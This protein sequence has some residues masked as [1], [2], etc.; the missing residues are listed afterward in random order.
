MIG[1]TVSH[2]KILEYLGEGGMGVVYKAEDIILNRSVT[3][4]FLPHE[5]TR[6]EEAKKRFILEA[7]AASSLDHANICVVHEIDH[8]NDGQ[9]FICMNYYEGETL[10][11]KIEKGPLKLDEAIDI[12][13]QISQGLFKAHGKGIIHRDIKPANIFITNDGIVKILDFGLAKLSGQSMLTK[14]GS[15]VGTVAYMSPEQARGEEVD[16]LTDIWS[17]GAV[18]YEMLTGRLPFNND[19]EQAM[20]Y[21][22]IN[23]APEPITSVQTG[24]PL[25]LESIISKCLEKKSSN[26]YKHIDEL[27]V[28]LQKLK[29]HLESKRDVLKEVREENQHK[30][31]KKNIIRLSAA[32]FLVIIIV[33][34]GY[35]G[36]NHIMN[37]KQSEGI[38]SIAILPFADMSPAKDQEYLCDGMTE[39]ITTNLSRLQNLRVRGRSSVMQFKN[40]SKTIPQIGKELNVGYLVE[41][42]IRKVANRIRVTVQ[43]IKANDDYNLWANDYDRKLDD[44]FNVQDDIAKSVTEK[45]AT[46]ISAAEAENIKTRKPANTEAYEYLMKGKYFH[47]NKFLY[48]NDIGDF[49]MAEK[50]L[51]KSIECDSNY[52]PSYVELSDLY[53]TY[54]FSLAKS[55]T[56]KNKYM[57]LQEKYL[58]KAFQLDSGSAEINRVKGSIYFA[59][60]EREKAYYY[61]KRSVELDKNDIPN[62]REFSEFFLRIGL[63]DISLKYALRIIEM[64][65]LSISGYDMII[66][67]YWNKGNLDKAKMYNNKLLEIYPDD[68]YELFVYARILYDMKKYDQF[69]EIRCKLENMKTDS[70]YIKYLRVLMYIINGEKEKALK[71][72]T[73]SDRYFALAIMRLYDHFKMNDE[74]IQYL[75]EDFDRLKKREESWYIWLKNSTLFDKLRSNS[76]FQE[77]LEKH[78]KLYEENLKKYKDIL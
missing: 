44:I 71:T 66:A 21:S 52:A 54:Y 20:I 11:D 33:I 1:Q 36:L 27:I 25:E 68:T 55:S 74:F 2:Y 19:Y 50:M 17:L 49:A 32:I 12:T 65:P 78:R 59:K 73:K 26:R 62:N 13:I 58:Q 70:A 60:G 42:S 7:R 5:L 15:T 72:Y 61:Y 63:L 46:K 75:T 48:T 45:L 40:T 53:N 41:G 4:K 28:D 3:L 57:M 35:F 76:R 43:L 24:I 31:V 34:A 9:L 16:Y 8:T 22:I 47:G 18:F 77:L 56:E 39:Q 69:N 30:K 29:K 10:K 38:K 64:D 14:T 67:A 6:N 37:T 51:L 23:D